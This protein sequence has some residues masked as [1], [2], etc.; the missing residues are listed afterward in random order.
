MGLFSKLF[1]V[2]NKYADHPDVLDKIARR[3]ARCALEQ[4]SEDKNN[5]SRT[6]VS[7]DTYSLTLENT[8]EGYDYGFYQHTNH[9]YTCYGL[10][11]SDFG[12]DKV[13]RDDARLFL[14]AFLPFLEN[15]LKL[16]LKSY[17]P[18]ATNVSAIR[19]TYRQESHRDCD[20]TI[21]P[22]IEI[23]VS[24]IRKISSSSKSN[25]KQW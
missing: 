3:A 25:L 21:I 15:H 11:W 1:S 12:M 22:V 17:F 14:D 23:Y 6:Y 5:T 13:D 24:D 20:D 4:I 18:N 9:P 7:V 16:K 10:D 2:H 8:P 19:T